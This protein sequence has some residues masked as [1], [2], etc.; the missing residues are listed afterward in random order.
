[1]GRHHRLRAAAAALLLLA[2][3]ACSGVDGSSTAGSK[4]TTTTT[5]AL[6]DRRPF[7]VG[8]RSETLTDRSRRTPA[9]PAK[10]LEE[11]PTRTI[12]LTVL[13]PTTGKG[14]PLDNPG[15]QD[16]ADGPPPPPAD[17][18]GAVA[19]GKFPLLVFA[20][21]WNGSG[22]SL[23]GPAKAWAAAGYVVALPTFPVSKQGIADSSDVIHQPGDVSFVIDTLLA[24]HGDDRYLQ[25]HI[26]ADR[27]AVGGHSLGSV[28]A[29]GFEN[30][31]CKD[32]RVKAIVAIS[33]GPQPYSTGDYDKAF[34]TPMLLVHGRKDPGVSPGISQAVFDATPGTFSLL[35]LDQATH[36][37]QFGGEDATVLS[38]VMVAFLDRELGIDP[39]AMDG[40][41]AKVAASGRGSLR[42]K[43]H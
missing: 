26:D 27:I 38:Q 12:P 25:G 29:F 33:G 39:H 23:V 10:M 21:G 16:G 7:P 28:T 31:C 32:P 37:S 11:R 15:L 18:G 3:V 35:M 13:Y 17:T 41:E 36:T 19:P 30:S 14:L 8:A 42:S 43:L 24:A 20:H 40:L 5:Q 22:T 2:V 1:V 34:A 6:P 4:P 9:V